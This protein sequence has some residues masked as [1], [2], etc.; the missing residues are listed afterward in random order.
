MADILSLKRARKAK[1]RAEKQ[2][3]AAENSTR[4]GLTK[5]EKKRLTAEQKRAADKLN[6]H[7]RED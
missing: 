6:A 3:A 5:A 7:K 1:E 4:Y 2:Q